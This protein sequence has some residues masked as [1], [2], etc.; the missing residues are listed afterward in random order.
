MV[1]I[2]GQFPAKSRRTQVEATQ[3]C[4][5]R[6]QAIVTSS[7]RSDR[8]GKHSR[9]RDVD[10]PRLLL[11]WHVEEWRQSLEYRL[12]GRCAGDP[13]EHRGRGQTTSCRIIEVKQAAE[14]FARAI[15]D[16]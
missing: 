11:E 13:S 6:E 9:L 7:K 16:L 1:R 8:G 3:A 10:D 14:Q 2:A 4:D 15:K 5:D 12:A